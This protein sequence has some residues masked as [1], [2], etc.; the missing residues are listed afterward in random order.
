MRNEYISRLRIKTQHCAIGYINLFVDM[1]FLHVSA[2]VCHLKGAP[3]SLR[4]TLK[5][6]QLCSASKI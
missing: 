6:G 2:T 4:F 1:R 5:F 3:L